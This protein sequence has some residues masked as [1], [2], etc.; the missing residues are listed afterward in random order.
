MSQGIRRNIGKDG[1]TNQ[2]VA[3]TWDAMLSMSGL[4]RHSQT[5]PRTEIKGREA[6]NAPNPGLR[7]AISETAAMMMPDNAALMARYNIP[8]PLYQPSKMDRVNSCVWVGRRR[9]SVRCQNL[10]VKVAEVVR[11][12]IEHQEGAAGFA[13]S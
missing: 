13:V 12:M 10:A 3:S 7:F 11:M 1:R 9:G 6:T 4:S 2:N 8:Q 5:I